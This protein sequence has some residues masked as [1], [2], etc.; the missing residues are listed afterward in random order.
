M[1]PSM[2]SPS[3]SGSLQVPPSLWSRLDVRVQQQLAQ[4]LSDLIRRM[5][6]VPTVAAKESSYEID[7]HGS[8]D[9]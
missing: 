9:H 5:R 4:C 6:G 3:P 7:A 8:Q 2:P 1:R